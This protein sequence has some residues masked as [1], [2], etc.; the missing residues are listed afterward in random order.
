MHQQWL[1][2]VYF[3]ITSS[4]FGSTI[5]KVIL[6]RIVIFVEQDDCWSNFS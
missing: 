5:S 1:I 3:Y 4:M 6:I 2:K